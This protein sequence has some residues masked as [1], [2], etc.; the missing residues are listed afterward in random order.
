MNENFCRTLSLLRHEKGISQRAASASLG[1]SQAL[2]SHYEKG[3]REPGLAFVT[4]ACDYYGVSAD[5]LL[6]RTLMRDGALLAPEDLHDAENDKDNRLRGNVAALLHKKLLLGA[7]SLLFDLLGQTRDKTLIEEASAYLGDGVYV[8]FRHLYDASGENPDTVFPL[9]GALFPLYAASDMAL[10]EARLSARLM[11]AAGKK[12]PEDALP[13]LS[14]DGL[15]ADYPQLAKSL[16][17]LLQQ[18]GDRIRENG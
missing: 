9:P 14:H 17:L 12:R 4:R 13:P 8:L 15:M 6:G 16:L 10:R 7:I 3:A 11:P 2:L 18:A 5:Y 1:V